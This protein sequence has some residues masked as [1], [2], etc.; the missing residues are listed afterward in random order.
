MEKIDL[1]VHTTY[2]DGD[3]DIATLL[4][5]AKKREIKT[6]AITDH[7][8]IIGLKGYKK[9]IK[10][11]GINIIPAIEMNVALSGV[12]ILGYGIKKL[13]R[14]EKFFDNI[15]LENENVVYDIIKYLKE[16]GLRIDEC[17]VTQNTIE[18]HHNKKNIIEFHSDIFKYQKKFVLAKNDVARTMRDLGI[19]ES[20]NDAYNLYLNRDGK[21]YCIKTKKVDVRDALEL[22]D[23][24]GGITS[25]AHPMTVRT[26]K[27][28]L[29]NI[30]KEL[31]SYG[32]SG[33]EVDGNHFSNK[34]IIQY[35]TIAEKL[36][37]IETIG[38]DFHRLDQEMGMFV[39]SKIVS[40]L[41]QK[42]KGLKLIK[43]L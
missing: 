3:L 18:Y 9:A 42:I 23:S 43:H 10:K 21:K 16:D 36:D 35:R 33:I 5:E 37:L 8:T 2:S 13:S 41:E 27:D 40:D 4:L 12:H 22:I 32:L 6:I 24:C 25:L 26:K 14:V 30:C 29:L 28:S 20:I 7:E 34:Q 1:H 39:S 38:S 11:Y 31:K 15:R 17:D 19:V